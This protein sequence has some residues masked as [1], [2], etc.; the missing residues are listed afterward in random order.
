MDED[1]DIAPIC[2]LEEWPIDRIRES[3]PADVRED[4]DPLHAQ[5]VQRTL[6]LAERRVRVVHRYRGEAEEPSGVLRGELGVRVIGE[7]GDL[8][9]RFALDEI[10]VRRREGENLRVDAD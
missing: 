8:G 7:P 1:A 4:D 10:D 5:L 9:L 3:A 6:E 2:L